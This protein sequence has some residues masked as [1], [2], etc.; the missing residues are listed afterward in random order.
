[1]ELIYIS[2]NITLQEIKA[3]LDR[4][5]TICIK[6]IAENDGNIKLYTWRLLGEIK[7]RILPMFE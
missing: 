3:E 6:N 5:T 1:L 7:G 2:E 4:I